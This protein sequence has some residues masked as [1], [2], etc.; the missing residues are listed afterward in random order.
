MLLRLFSSYFIPSFSS[1]DEY[2]L[3]LLYEITLSKFF[4]NKL[5][6]ILNAYLMVNRI[7]KRLTS[8]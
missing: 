1:Q 4:L 6:Y 7:T 2:A 3:E 5:N 8:T